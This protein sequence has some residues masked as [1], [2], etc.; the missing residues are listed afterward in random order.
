MPTSI[1]TPADSAVFTNFKNGNETKLTYALKWAAWKWEVAERRVLG[2]EVRLE[3][4]FG[5]I[6]DVVGLGP[7]N[8]VFLIEVKSSKSDLRR[9]D[10]NE[11]S[12]ERLLKKAKSLRS[13][14]E[15]SA[16]I[17]AEAQSASTKDVSNRALAVA[18][19]DVEYVTKKLSRP[20]SE[21][22]HFRPSSTIPPICD[23]PITTTS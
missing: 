2:F 3:G 6:T 20:R 4:P 11:R 22:K 9:D 10:N 15:L 13:A 14:E 8:R 1:E 21:S 5:R 12:Q 18:E 16:N 17:L 7:D 19:S 23:A